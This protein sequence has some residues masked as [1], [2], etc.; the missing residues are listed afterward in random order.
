[1]PNTLYYGDNLEV[2]RKY[3]RDETVDLCY[4]DPPFNSKR[5]YNQI[6]D[7]VGS[8][9][10]AQAQAFID[11][12]LWD[13]YALEGFQ[14]IL[15]NHENRFRPSTIEL[16]K[17]LHR[18]LGEGSLL[19]YIISMTLRI[20]EIHRVLKPEGGFYLHCD[21]NA[22]HYLK[23]ALD[24]IFGTENYRNEI[25]WRRAATIKGNSGQGSKRFDSN[26]DTILFYR[27]SERN[28]FNPIFREYS[29]EYLDKFYKYVEPET[30]KQYRLISMIGPGGAA[31]GNPQYEVMGVTKYWR[32]SREKMQELID[33]GL[34]VQTKPGNVPVRKQYL[35]DGKGVAVQS[36]WDD[37]DALGPSSN[38]RLGY[39]TQKPEALL[40]RIILA[41]TNPDSVVLDA[42]CG[43]GTTVSVAERL[44]R[45]WIGIDITYQSIAIVLN[46]LEGQFGKAAVQNILLNGIPRDMEAARALAKKRDDRLRKEFEKWA[47][48]TYTNNRA[49]IHE[50]KGADAG[51]DGIAYFQTSHA[52]NASIIFQVKSG[53]VGRG[54]IAALRGDMERERAAMATFISLE[55]PTKPMLEEARAAGLYHHALMDRHYP[56]IQTVT[57]QD[58]VEREKRLDIPMSLAVLRAA[59]QAQR[60]GQLAFSL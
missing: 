10:R 39:P 36:L 26:T 23:V 24:S 55:S 30:G 1:M 25:I 17:G 56:R 3:I 11:T 12:W 59:E 21:S 27:K 38:E 7:K 46:R 15:S 28:T 58:I 32:Y 35:E 14:E 42:Y 50:K 51:I 37:I 22:S 43:C 31:K 47:I 49:L 16:I 4:I 18:V 57:V 54:D 40:E 33:A 48:L 53:G 13:V 52:D 34:V 60:G 29:E 44:G 41:S 45:R 6:Y 9:D 5:N 20:T 19:A 8:G 2:L